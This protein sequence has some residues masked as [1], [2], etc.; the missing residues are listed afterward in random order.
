MAWNIVAEQQVVAQEVER[1]QPPFAHLDEV[2]GARDR[3]AHHEQ[4][5]LLQR[6]HDL[7]AVARIGQNREMHEKCRLCGL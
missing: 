6:I 7:G 4:H 1:L 5:D 2:V 3:G